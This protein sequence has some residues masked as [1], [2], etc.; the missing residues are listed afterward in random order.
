MSVWTTLSSSSRWYQPHLSRPSVYSTCVDAASSLRWRSSVAAAASVSLKV[1]V[2]SFMFLLSDAAEL[3]QWTCL[4]TG[5]LCVD[6]LESLMTNWSFLYRYN[7]SLD[8]VC[9]WWRFIHLTN[10]HRSNWRNTIGQT[11]DQSERRSRWCYG[12]LYYIQHNTQ[13]IKQPSAFLLFCL[14]RI[15]ES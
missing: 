5:S 8:R 12:E 2:S 1:K 11:S 3:L 4:F 6:F 10:R 9:F 15:T 13:H 7:L 14:L